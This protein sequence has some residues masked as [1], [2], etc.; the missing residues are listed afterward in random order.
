MDPD[1][2]QLAFEDLE[3]A[4]AEAEAAGDALNARNADGTQRRPAAKRILSGFEGI[5]QVDGHTGYDALAEPRRVG[6]MPLTLA[7]C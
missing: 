2:R 3:T 6:G 1:E 7:Y 5:L 4:V